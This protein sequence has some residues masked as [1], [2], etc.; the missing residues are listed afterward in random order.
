MDVD[1]AL[2]ADGVAQRP[3]GKLDIF[4]AAIDIIFAPQ[5]PAMHPQLSLVLRILVTRHEAENP[6][7]IDVIL[8]SADGAEI[9][10]ARGETT[11]LTAE[12]LDAVPAGRRIALQ[13]VLAFANLVF[14][15]HGSYHFAIHWD[16]T[17]ARPPIALHVS[18]PPQAAA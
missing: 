2:L 11:P 15:T 5:T 12:Q 7:T 18:Q 10:R 8:L 3:D 17:E 13:A 4:G 1:F 14:P 16:G 6:H 9:A